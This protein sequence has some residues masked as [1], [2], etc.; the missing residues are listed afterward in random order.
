ML[1]INILLIILFFIILFYD[2]NLVEGQSIGG[3]SYDYGKIYSFYSLLTD[4][5]TIISKISISKYLGF[6]LHNAMKS[7]NSL[8]YDVD[9]PISD[10][11][12]YKNMH[13]V[14]TLAQ[15]KKT[16]LKNAKKSI[17]NTE[18]TINSFLSPFKLEIKGGYDTSNTSNTDEQ[19]LDNDDESNI[20]SLVD[21]IYSNNGVSG[22]LVKSIT[23]EYGNCF[24]HEEDGKNKFNEL[25]EQSCYLQEDKL[26]VC[27]ETSIDNLK[28]CEDY[29]KIVNHHR[30]F[31]HIKK[32]NG[33]YYNCVPNTTQPD[34]HYE[35]K[36]CIPKNNMCKSKFI[37]PVTEGG[38][39]NTF[40]TTNMV[41]KCED[42]YMFDSGYYYNCQKDNTNHKDGAHACTKN[43]KIHYNKP[44][45][46]T[47]KI[48]IMD[49]E[50]CNFQ[51]T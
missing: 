29:L 51:Y 21:T 16:I 40:D 19:I 41:G 26:E 15:N 23:D 12:K 24:T 6:D 31:I 2:L 3:E 33:L 32:D 50:Y 14:Q 34:Y 42:H 49:Y 30:E 9:E 11:F 7:H 28:N 36:A 37:N 10:E 46:D 38:D 5:N 25:C 35:E 39:C 45:I 44:C 43:L 27:N 20:C 22:S 17:I 18:N 4:L 8:C 1:I 48:D 47:S 13:V